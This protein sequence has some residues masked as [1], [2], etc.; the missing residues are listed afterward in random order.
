MDASLQL[1]VNRRFSWRIFFIVWA[2]CVFGVAAVIP[3]SLA[4]QGGAGALE[5]VSMPLPLLLALQTLQNAVL[6]AIVVGIGLLLATRIGLGLPFLEGWLNGQP[7]WGKLPRVALLAAVLGAVGAVLVVALDATVFAAAVKDAVG[8]AGIDTASEQ[9]RP[10]WWKGFLASFYGG[11]A[12]EALLR[13]LFLTLL[14]W[15]GHF[16]GRTSEGRPN[17]AVLW[18]ANILAAVLFGLGH[19]PTAVAIGIPLT[20]MFVVRTV[21]LN[22][23]IGVVA[24]WL[25]WTRGLESAMISHFSADIVLHVILPLIS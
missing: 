15:L 7:V 12:E 17:L 18:T 23:L 9:L 14:A 16:L 22:G 4:V 5:Q 25:Y 6:F 2:G 10:A 3:Y 20:G 11:I 19:L 1:P 13:L 8:Q 21:V 24:G